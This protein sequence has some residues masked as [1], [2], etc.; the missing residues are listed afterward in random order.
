MTALTSPCSN[1][2]IIRVVCLHPELQ[3]D[4]S[5]RTV[6]TAVLGLLATPL[7]I[8]QKVQA[9]ATRKATAGT[10]PFAVLDKVSGVLKAGSV[11]LLLSPPGHGKTSFLR[12][13]SGRIPWSKLK[14]TVAYSGLSATEAESRGINLKQL[15]QYV[16]QLD[17]HLPQLTVRETFEFAHQNGTVDPSLLGH[18]DLAASAARKVE[19]IIALLS[20]Q[21]CSNT[22]VGNDLVRGVS[23]G[24][25]K[26]VTI[27]ES[28]VT[29]ARVLMMD[30]ISTGLDSAVTFDIVSG[31]RSWAKATG[32]TVVIALLQ[33]TP[34]VYSLFDDVLMLREG[35]VVYHGSREDLP[36]YVTGLGYYPPTASHGVERARSAPE[37][38]GT[39]VLAPTGAG[40]ATAAAVDIADWLV[41]FLTHPSHAWKAGFDAAV[42]AGK[43]DASAGSSVTPTARA[44]G[45][46]HVPVTTPELVQAWMHSN[47]HDKLLAPPPKE[48]PTL[49]LTTPFAKAQYGRSYPRTWMQHFGSLL[50]RQYKLTARN[51]LFLTTR[52]VGAIVMAIIL[53]TVFINIPLENGADKFGMFLF[54]A[55][56]VA[57]ANFSE[58]PIA[59]VNKYTCY[60]H[61]ASAM[62]PSL[63]YVLSV[64]LLH[65][66]IAIAESLVFSVII[67]FL[68]GLVAEAGRFFFFLCVLFFTDVAMASFFRIFAYA[69]SDMESAQ[70]MP[71]PI[72]SIQMLMAGF[73]IT[74]SKLGWL[75]WL[76]YLSVFGYALRSL[77]QN[78]FLSDAYK[79]QPVAGGPT[80]GEIFLGYF[81]M[82]TEP[83]W[84]WGGV[85]FLAFFAIA[86]NA[87]SGLVLGYVRIERNIGTSRTSSTELTD[88]LSPKG[89]SSEEGEGLAVA[90]E[91]A[92]SA[93]TSP[94][95]EAAAGSV[96]LS[97]VAS[98]PRMLPREP[99]TYADEA[100][101][102]TASAPPTPIP[103]TRA[104]VPATASSV[105]PFDP[106]T[107]VFSDIKYCVTLPSK[108]RCVC[109]CVG[110][111]DCEC[112]RE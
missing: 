24:E 28:M 102:P 90:I 47:L 62:Y 95:A 3:V 80:L 23:G 45:L 40:G 83:E 65:I 77:A 6:G 20:L 96:P 33:P 37:G 103:S 7:T 32:G 72:I 111:C 9:M 54:A 109:E 76:H 55:L 104:M 97:P 91:V 70:I 63:A 44:A 94:V 60:K 84:K 79:A 57:F 92:G 67:Y 43:V 8:A 86:M 108:W 22:V 17:I 99:D 30:E 15:V 29:N 41:E 101:S 53:G 27:G 31:I 87:I 26:R 16:D 2:C 39:G 89:A 18:P 98:D 50:V 1:C 88:A 100:V 105:M 10:T 25:K 52:I 14:G 59:V 78:E 5:M 68:V 71:G 61:V 4:R 42:A 112:C 13:L 51:Q 35:A 73:L 82:Q 36:Q 48:Q 85:G 81:D 69:A 56:Q 21:G 107:V 34:E 110:V 38:S 12:A 75:I 106:M 11:T 93:A 49:A 19:D 58:V 46:E 64:S 74:R 66:P